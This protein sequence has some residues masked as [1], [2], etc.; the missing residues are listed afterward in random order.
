MS[1]AA[2]SSARDASE[3]SESAAML[4]HAER[5]YEQLEAPGEGRAKLPDDAVTEAGKH[6][7]AL[8]RSAAEAAEQADSTSHASDAASLEVTQVQAELI[9]ITTSTESTLAEL[10]REAAQFDEAVDEFDAAAIR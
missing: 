4:R 8:R 1:A 3:A 6:L 7:E 2:A 5:A 10:Q 9:S